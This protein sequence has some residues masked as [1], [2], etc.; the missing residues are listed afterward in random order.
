MNNYFISDLDK[1]LIYTK[2]PNE[3]CVEYKD[4]KP[5]SYMTEKGLS[6]MKKI[7]TKSI[8]IPCTM[9]NLEQT[10]R[11]NFIKEYNPKFIICQNGANIYINGKL[12]LEWAE[13]IS[14]FIKT[15]ELEFMKKGIELLNMP[16]DRIKIIE[17]IN[18][19]IK[20]PDSS[21]CTSFL[22]L[23]KCQAFE[24]YQVIHAKGRRKIN[25]FHKK[26]NKKYAVEYLIKK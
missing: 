3:I 21:M 6:L 23:I 8:F 22:N 12:D 2:Y 7:L 13:Y 18:I 5:I 4:G 24:W 10:M 20:F 11:I 16:I 17:G 25:I 1:T 19:E 15:D 14:Q 26:I 9:R